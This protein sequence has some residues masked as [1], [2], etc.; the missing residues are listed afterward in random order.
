[1]AL[2]EATQEML[3]AAGLPA[4]EISNH[5]R[6]GQE[7]RHNLAYWRSQ[8]Y[9]GIGPGAHGRL[10]AGPGRYA[11]RQYRAPET[12]LEAVEKHGHGTEA[13][14]RLSASERRAE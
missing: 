1:G 14:E 4:Y 10:D 9:A 6:P 5:A 2:Y 11:A 7:C 3:G 8:D 13:I 12:W